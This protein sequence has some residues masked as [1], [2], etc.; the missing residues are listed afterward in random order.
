MFQLLMGLP[1]LRIRNVNHAPPE[2]GLGDV[3]VPFA[4]ILSIERGKLGRHPRFCVDTV[5]HTGDRH[6]VH[7][8]AVPNISPK[9]TADFAV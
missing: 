5:G 6:F 9:R 2:I 3:L 4:K 8:H 7:G 1:E